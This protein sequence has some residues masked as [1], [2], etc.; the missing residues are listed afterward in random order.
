MRL[1]YHWTHPRFRCKASENNSRQFRSWALLRIGQ[2]RRGSLDRDHRVR[3]K[4]QEE[5]VE[6]LAD[7]LRPG[8]RVDGRSAGESTADR[9]GGLVDE[10][11]WQ[12]SADPR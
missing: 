9:L 12:D 2:M 7:L 3:I 1:F 10:E 11:Y 6:T 5:Y 4:W 8:M